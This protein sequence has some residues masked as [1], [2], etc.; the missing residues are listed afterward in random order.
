LR[1]QG[2]Y[3]RVDHRHGLTPSNVIS[4]GWQEPEGSRTCLL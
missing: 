4:K 2:L 1:H 3:V